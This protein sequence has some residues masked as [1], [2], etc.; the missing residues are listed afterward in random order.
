MRQRV[1]EDLPAAPIHVDRRLIADPVKASATAALKAKVASRKEPAK[2]KEEAP[3]E[4][5]STTGRLL[6]LKRRMRGKKDGK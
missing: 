3:P 6:E 2:K 5:V 4:D 1:D